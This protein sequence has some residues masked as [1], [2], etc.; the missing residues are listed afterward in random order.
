VVVAAAEQQVKA[1]EVAPDPATRDSKARETLESLSL[2][3]GWDGDASIP[4]STREWL[5]WFVGILVTAFA[6]ML[7]AP[8]WFDVLNKIMVVRST[9]KP[10][11]S[12]PKVDP[13]ADPS[14]T[15][16]VVALP[17][18]AASVAAADHEHATGSA[19]LLD[20][21]DVDMALDPTPDEDLPPARGGVANP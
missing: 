2:P 15:Q 19:A 14:P 17:A 9:L 8:F 3:I 10:G 20:T 21:C 5:R 18:V 1:Q 16:R 12:A 6:A 4:T 11:A 7:G 13:P